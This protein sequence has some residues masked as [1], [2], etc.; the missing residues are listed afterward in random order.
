ML[1][2]FAGKVLRPLN[3]DPRNELR[4]V[5]LSQVGCESLLHLELGSLRKWWRLTKEEAQRRV[6]GFLNAVSKNFLFYPL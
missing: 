5:Y 4:G 1:S 2:H 6:L 3:L